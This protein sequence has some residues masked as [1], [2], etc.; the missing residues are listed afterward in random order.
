MSLD[1]T[2]SVAT[3]GFA[4][5]F[6]LAATAGANPPAKPATKNEAAAQ[7]TVFGVALTSAKRQDIREAAKKEGATPE[8]EDDKYWFDIYSAKDL[9]DGAEKLQ[10]GYVAATGQLAVLEYVLPSFMDT[11]QVAR[12]SSM[13]QAKYGAPSSKKGNIGLGNVVHTWNRKDG[14]VITVSRGW[15][16]TTTSLTFTVPAGKKAMDAEIAANEKAKVEQQSQKNSRAF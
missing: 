5:V 7:T 14:V 2:V 8:R 4:V 13:V 9:L 15:P 10:V 11:E 1:R 6:L 16:S 12:I 3:T